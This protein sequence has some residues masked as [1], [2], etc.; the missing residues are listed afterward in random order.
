MLICKLSDFD[1]LFNLDSLY[2]KFN[3]FYKNICYSTT[4]FKIKVFF[5]FSFFVLLHAM[6]QCLGKIYTVFF[7]GN[8]WNWNFPLF[9]VVTR[10]NLLH[11]KKVSWYQTTISLVYLLYMS[12][13]DNVK[14]QIMESVSI[15]YCYIS[16]LCFF[17]FFFN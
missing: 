13:T 8:F 12:C 10:M 9:T 17:F 1:L 7:Q 6:A 16:F 5:Q 4:V 3:C 11:F 15:P 2:N 14:L